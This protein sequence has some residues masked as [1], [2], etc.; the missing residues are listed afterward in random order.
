MEQE[1]KY[2]EPEIETMPLDKLRKLQEERLQEIV[3]YAYERTKFYR[4]KF[5]EAGVKPS[6]INT[7][8]DL[9]KLPLIED[10]E[11]RH[12]P[13]EDKLGVPWEE[14]YHCCSSSGTTGFPEPIAFTKNDFAIGCLDSVARLLWT[15]GI[16]PSD[17]VQH[18][19][20]LP[21]ISQITALM[22]ARNMGEQ[23]GRGRL[24]NQIVLGNMMH[25]TVLTGMPT[26]ALSYFERAKELG[27]DIRETD[28]RLVVG[29]GEGL[30]ESFKKKAKDEFGPVF[31]DYYAASTFGEVASE[32][33]FG[34]GMHIAADRIILEVIDPKTKQLLGP[35]KE[36]ELVGTNL[37]RKGIPRIRIRIEDVAKMLPYEPCPC[38]RT[39]PKMSKIRG[40]MVQ[41]LRVSGKE[42]FP[43]DVE[44]ALG[45][46]PDLGYE[47]QIIRDKPELDRLKVRVE[48]K[49]EIKDLQ[50]LANR[51]EEA[52]Y[53]RLGV[54]SEVEL[55]PKGSIGRA[56]FK[57]QRVIT[58]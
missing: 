26:I 8:D 57:A 20:G 55:V 54:G 2:W 50:A 28:L 48:Y 42:F 44:E 32:C 53:E 18:T 29:F 16:R 52:F 9:A 51:V 6:D 7:L 23:A 5:D 33:D 38:G 24:D 58:A 56:M 13:M 39:L 35:G 40:R 15:T 47:Y 22:G 19:M 41:L 4:R 46:I 17:R 25:I 49:P 37:I 27:I 45:D 30:A 11:I 1:G 43:I 3:A 34:G 10:S 12:A 21:C 14:I 31:R 36:G